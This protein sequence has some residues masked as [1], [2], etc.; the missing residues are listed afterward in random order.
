MTSYQDCIHT[1]PRVVDLTNDS[2]DFD[3]MLA[4]SLKR[5]GIARQDKTGLHTLKNNV[6]VRRLEFLGFLQSIELLNHHAPRFGQL[7]NFRCALIF[8]RPRPLGLDQ[9]TLELFT[10]LFL[11]HPLSSRQIQS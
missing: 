10:I 5:F 2:F 6:N 3:G 7:V 9:N 1:V 4:S 11:L 8:Y